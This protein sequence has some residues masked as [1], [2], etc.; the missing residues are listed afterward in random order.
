MIFL[1]WIPQESSVPITHATY[2]CDS[3]SIYASFGDGS[4]GVFTSTTLILRCR[5]NPTAYL[6][7]NISSRVHPLV[8]AAH[9][10]EPNQI[11]LGLSD[12]GVYVVEPLESEGKWGTVPPPE[13]GAGPSITSGQAGGSDQLPR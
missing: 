13:N 1:Q 12:G 2:S 3:Q 8:I 10:T 11:A 4:V 5:I 6:S 9:P 7:P